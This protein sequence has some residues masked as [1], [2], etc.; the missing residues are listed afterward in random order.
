VNKFLFDTSVYI[1]LFCDGKYPFDSADDSNK[2]IYLSTVVAQELFAGALNTAGV[3]AID[4]LV[5]AF[6]GL[7][8][9][10]TP[11]WGD[12]MI[13]G[14]T[15]AAI[16]KKHGFESVKRGRLVNDVLIALTS[17]HSG[18]VL[19]TANE[20]DFGMIGKFIEFSWRLS[21]VL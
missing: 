1:P 6:R 3:K 9:L 2:I 8:R 13:C 11:S 14:K 17:H 16:G 15:I 20:K 18:A 7:D 10:L 19:I 5:N 21:G 12:W 4:Q